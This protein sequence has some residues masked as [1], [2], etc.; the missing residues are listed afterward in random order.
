MR[1]SKP[2]LRQV[3]RFLESSLV[4]LGL[5]VPAPLLQHQVVEVAAVV[6]VATEKGEVFQI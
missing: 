5:L 2:T 6:V 3:K 1:L 4:A